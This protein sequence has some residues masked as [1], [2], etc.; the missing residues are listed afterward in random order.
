MIITHKN[1]QPFLD[2]LMAEPEFAIGSHTRPEGGVWYR[3]IVTLEFPTGEA[4]KDGLT[5]LALMGSNSHECVPL[6]GKEG[7]DAQGLEGKIQVRKD[8]FGALMALRDI[9]PEHRG[10]IIADSMG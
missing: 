9:L 3:Q 2:R 6:T 1:L 8:L 10:R 5:A 4:C 7:F